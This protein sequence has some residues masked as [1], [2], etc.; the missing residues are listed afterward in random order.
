MFFD[1]FG[2]DSFLLLTALLLFS[3]VLVAKFSSRWGIP[4]LILFIMVGMAFGS[5]GLGIVYFSDAGTAQVI[6]VFALVIILFEGG[7]HTKWGTVRSVAVPSLSLATIGVLIT[8]LIV[9]LAAYF[10]FELSWLESFLFGAIVGS[11]DAAA[12]FAALKERNI[13]AKM[14][15]TLEA[16]SGT[17]DPMAVFLTLSL[18]ELIT[19]EQSSFWM[20]IP[21]FFLQMG[22][23]LIIGLALGKFASLSINRI[24]LD[25]SA[26]YPIFS[27]AFALATYSI[28]AFSGGSG[29]LGVY[30]AALVIGNSELTYRYSI[31]QFNEGFAWMAQ[32][33]MFVILGL[34]V[35][36]SELFTPGII[37]NGILLSIVLIL[38]ARPIAVFLS[39]F[40]MNYSTKEKLFI[41]WAGLRGAVPIVLAT[42]PIV[43]G[44]QNSQALFNLVFFV[45]LTSALVQGSTIS[46]VAKKMNLVG[47]KKDIPH[48]SIEL[49]SMGKAKA[50]MIQYQTNAESAVVGKK[51]HEVSF[52]NRANISAII[53]NNEVITPYGETEIKAGDFLYILVEE[54]Y[55]EQLKKTLEQRVQKSEQLMKE[56]DASS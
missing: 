11:T 49:I 14:G 30:V 37:V 5:E 35:F 7:L 18:I 45:V 9:G 51:L 47:P 46:L 10:L 2:T 32:I 27:V 54:K 15:A 36:P 17:N 24:K 13:K 53:R 40:K 25:S 3:G 28:T 31:F 12:V 41:S 33:L 44:L 38:I 34:Y 6:G 39:L 4:A 21:T 20:L 23:G 1:A 50:E 42:F 55:K 43:E 29:F 22:L 52:P 56:K 26:L 16:E 19:S 8:S 48:H